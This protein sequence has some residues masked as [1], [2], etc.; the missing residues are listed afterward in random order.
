MF[1]ESVPT[2]A[3]AVLDCQQGISVFY[4]ENLSCFLVVLMKKIHRNIHSHVLTY[5]LKACY[6]SKGGENKSLLGAFNLTE[7]TF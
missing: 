3:Q 4:Y 2:L 1:T 6:N 5:P 7:M